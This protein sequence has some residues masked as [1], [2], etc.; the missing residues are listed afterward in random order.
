M[1]EKEINHML[2]S[3]PLYLEHVDTNPNSLIA[4]IYGIFT[5]RM[6]QFEPIHVMIMQNTIPAIEN[7]ELQYVFDLKGSQINR[8]VLKE[9]S[10]KDI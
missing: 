8:E 5:V 4:K 9:V 2:R 1:H 3:L 7:T 6:D 10:N